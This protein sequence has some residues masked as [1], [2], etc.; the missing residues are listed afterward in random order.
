MRRYEHVSAEEVVAR[1]STFD[2]VVS[3]EVI[4]H[5]N[6]PTEFCNTLADLAAEGGALVVTTMNR[7]PKSYALAIV[8][9]EKV[10]GLAPDGAHDWRKFVTPAELQL[11]C[12]PHGFELA[13]VAGMQMNV[14]NGT[15]YLGSDTDVNYAALLTRARP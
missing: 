12:A 7:T 11:M 10:L 13:E 14:L 6:K 8:V 3:S 15:W 9:A 1:G 2:L 4:E 5:V